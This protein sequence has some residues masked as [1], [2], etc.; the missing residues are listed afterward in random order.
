MSDVLE[1]DVFDLEDDVN[2]RFVVFEICGNFYGIEEKNMQEIITEAKITKVPDNPDY[3]LGI[4]SFRR[5]IITVIDLNILTG[6]QKNSAPSVRCI[7]A[8][9][10][11]DLTVGFAADN[12]VCI[13]SADSAKRKKNDA[14][15]VKGSVKL[16]DKSVL[17]ID[18]GRLTL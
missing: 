16:D 5:E 11:N 17:L 6:K 15:F 4:V 2:D 18:C 8:A 10:V 13:A 12:V 14:A 3:V 9:S 7:L 1:S